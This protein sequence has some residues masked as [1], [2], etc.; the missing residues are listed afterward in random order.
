MLFNF[1]Y[2]GTGNISNFLIALNDFIKIR[3][4]TPH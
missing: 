1:R 4:I 3:Y 2:C